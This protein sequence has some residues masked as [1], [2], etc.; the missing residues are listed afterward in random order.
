MIASIE[1]YSQTLPDSIV[2]TRNTFVKDFEGGENLYNTE[3]F[4]IIRENH[5]LYLDD[6]KTPKTKILDFLNELENKE[7]HIYSLSN[8]GLDTTWIKQNPEKLL[9]LYS[10]KK[11][12][13][14]NNE[15]KN[16]IYKKL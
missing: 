13:E 11:T 1:V 15:Q 12:I 7:N 2:I 14:W 4:V 5:K 10:D 6:K 16:F 9:P 3:M 8:Y